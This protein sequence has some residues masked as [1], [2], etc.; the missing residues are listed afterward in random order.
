MAIFHH[1]WLGHVYPTM[2]LAWLLIAWRRGQGINNN[3]A[4]LLSYFSPNIPLVRMRFWV[5]VATLLALS[6]SL[7]GKLNGKGFMGKA[8]RWKHWTIHGNSLRNTMS[9]TSQTICFSVLCNTVKITNNS[10]PDWNSVNPVETSWADAYLV[11][12]RLRIGILV[13][14]LHVL[15]HR[16]SITVI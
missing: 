7:W 11:E 5:H 10:K 3:G 16:V 2:W 4:D 6:L 15:H 14:A 9:N 8:R 1:G 12:T 13:F